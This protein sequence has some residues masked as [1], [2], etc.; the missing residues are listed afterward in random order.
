MPSC[1]LCSRHQ[2]SPVH[3]IWSVD[4]NKFLFLITN[5]NNYVGVAAA[6]AGVDDVGDVPNVVG[7]RWL[8]S[9]EEEVWIYA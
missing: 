3:E 6:K 1:A 2:S 5:F 9:E 7:V 4:F 8:K